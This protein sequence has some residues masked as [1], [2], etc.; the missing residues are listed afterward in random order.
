LNTYSFFHKDIEVFH[1]IKPKLKNLYLSINES[2]EVHLK[3]PRINQK[4][5]YE[6]LTNKELWI[7]KKLNE[8]DGYQKPKVELNKE[9]L[10]LGS[11]YS[12]EDPKLINLKTMLL[13]SRNFSKESLI[14]K[15]DLFYKG[16][17]TEY[18]D[19]RASF[20]AKKMNLEYQ[21]IKLRKMKRRWGSCNSKKILTFNTELMK[22]KKELIDYVVVHELAHLKHMNH[23]KD[24]H[25]LVE[26]YLP[27][28][29]NLKLELQ[30]IRIA[31]I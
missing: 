28:S 25:A 6:L 17:A 23:S 11:I 8:I 18:L 31:F 12:L 1:S 30:K 15:Y 20:Y 14:K 9:A 26:R 29:N 19:Q 22:I 4:Q 24:F 27:D 3:T 16:Y 10:L 13:K 21:S 2:G 7:R 5:I